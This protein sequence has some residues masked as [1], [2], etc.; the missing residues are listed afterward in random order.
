MQTSVIAY[1]LLCSFSVAQEEDEEVKEKE[2][3]DE[4]KV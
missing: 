4:G 3:E 1:T 2:E